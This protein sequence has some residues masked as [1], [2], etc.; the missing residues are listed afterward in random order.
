M[1]WSAR[2]SVVVNHG[3]VTRIVRILNH[4]EC[5]VDVSLNWFAGLD[6]DLNGL[7]DC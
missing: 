4:V 3:E 2:V 7:G 6:F 1:V 5:D